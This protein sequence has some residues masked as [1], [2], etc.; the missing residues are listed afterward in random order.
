MTETV[1]TYDNS[2]IGLEEEIKV[3]QLQSHESAYLF[4]F[5]NEFSVRVE[6]KIEVTDS[7]DSDFTQGEYL[8]G[9]D[10]ELPS[11][12]VPKNEYESDLITEPW[13]KVR[14]RVHPVQDPSSGS[15]EIR[16]NDR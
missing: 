5:I 1:V 9:E 8:R 13:D 7:M 11:L 2:E 16:V 3:Y 12:T 15:F 14:F 6:V 4:R 10:S